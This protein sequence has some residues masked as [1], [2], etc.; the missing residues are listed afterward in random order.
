MATNIRTWEIVNG[1][2][3]P[4]DSSLEDYG[5]KE[6]YDLEAWISADPSIVRSGLKIIGRQIPTRTGPLDL[7]VLT[8]PVIST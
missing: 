5:R 2:P 6:A 8:A 3:R 4:I 1:Q 7:W